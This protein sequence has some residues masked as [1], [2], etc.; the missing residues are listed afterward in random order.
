MSRYFGDG[1][2]SSI[3]YKDG[4]VFQGDKETNKLG[5]GGRCHD[6]RLKK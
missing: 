1:G 2:V 6:R 5:R 3:S 4:D